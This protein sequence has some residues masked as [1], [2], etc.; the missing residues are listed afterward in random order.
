MAVGMFGMPW[1]G[2]KLA[3]AHYLAALTVGLIFRF[4]GPG[5]Q[6]TARPEPPRRG[7]ILR[8]AVERL[9]EARREDGRGLGQLAG[10]AVHES[11]RTLLVIC[12]FIM[13][14]S[15]FVRMLEVVGLRG[16]VAAPFVALFRLAGLPQELVPAAIAGLL[17]IDLGTRA[18]SVAPVAL[19]P[20]AVVASAIIAW[21]GLSVHGQVASVITGTDVRMGPYVVARVLHALFAA[22]Y[23]VP[24]LVPATSARLP[25]VP[26]FG[27]L[28]PGPGFWP[29][30]AG[31]AVG[32]VLV[33][34]L[35]VAVGLAAALVAR[36]VR[37]G[38]AHY[39]G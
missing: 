37:P 15:V 19:V 20:R 16:V 32:A 36:L 25:V 34:A 14:F 30:L 22:M 5:E 27:P 9:L 39:N 18:A 29:H 24:L 4:Y 17:E 6:E 11:V 7:N 38:R 21:S 33:P 26:V 1:L 13:L 10:D 31:S 35:L 28:E 3:A 8:R 2:P 23:I 12:G